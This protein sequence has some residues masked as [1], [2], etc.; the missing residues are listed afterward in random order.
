MDLL[1]DLPLGVGDQLILQELDLLAELFQEAEIAVHDAVDEGVGQVVRPEL[2][3]PPL[4]LAD[5]VPNRVE[6]SALLLLEGN[7]EVR[8]GTR[9]T[10]WIFSS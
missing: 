7:D 6:N 4:V 3:Q 10:C 8:P 9:L 1:K 2:P 5:P